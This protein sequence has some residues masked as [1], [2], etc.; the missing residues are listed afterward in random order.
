MS[1]V[2]AAG[3]DVLLATSPIF[4]LWNV[5]I[6][7]YHKSLLC[8]L[9]AL[10]FLQVSSNRLGGGEVLMN[11]LVQAQPGSSGQSILPSPKIQTILLVSDPVE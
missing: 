11:Y 5:Q 7:L 1:L 2:M 3:Y 6:S 8:G 10:G 9:L 4:L